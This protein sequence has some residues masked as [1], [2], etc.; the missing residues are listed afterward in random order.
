MSIVD[1]RI[2]LNSIGFF[3][4]IKELTS[5][6]I[7]NHD[8]FLHLN[9]DVKFKKTLN[10]L[11]GRDF[12]QIDLHLY[13]NFDANGNY[14]VIRVV[15]DTSDR[16]Y[17]YYYMFNRIERHDDSSTYVLNNRKINII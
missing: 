15:N 2:N 5:Y 12:I 8:E 11:Y 7:T 10:D 3:V 14:Y 13:I 16:T 6:I 1:L 9:S 17:L 4:N